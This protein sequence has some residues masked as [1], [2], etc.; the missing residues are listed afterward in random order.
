MPRL[1]EIRNYQRNWASVPAPISQAL[2]IEPDAVQAHAADLSGVLSPRATGLAWVGVRPAEILSGAFQSGALGTT[3]TL[4]QVTNLGVSVKDSPHSTLVFVTRLDNAAPVEGA[5]V[6]IVDTSNRERWR[7]TTD[8]DGVVIAPAMTLR[9]TN[10]T[11]QLAYV[12]TAEKDGDL[13]YVASDANGDTN[14]PAFGHPYELSE[15]GEVLRA[16][17]FTDRGVYRLGE[18]LHAKAILRADT[19]AGMSMLPEGARVQVLVQDS[20]R[21][22]VDRRT[23]PVN[24]WSSVEW[25]MQRARGRSAGQ[26]H[27]PRRS[28]W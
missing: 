11:W 1:L 3:G 8:R 7:G 15:A 5:A 24:R 10:N 27:D 18:E 26:L 28:R 4:L 9:A 25:T 6:A 22:E 19:P 13:A 2:R 12:V 20:R 14:P 23:V 21:R 17:I 16:S